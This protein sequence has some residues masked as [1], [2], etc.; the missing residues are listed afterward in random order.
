MSRDMAVNI[1]VLSICGAF[2]NA[3]RLLEQIRG[4]RE[5]YEGSTQGKNLLE[6]IQSQDLETSL[7]RGASVVQSQYDRDYK[8]YG[9]A[10]AR[11]DGELQCAKSLGCKS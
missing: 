4:F 7:H 3:A 1:C 8:R 5:S 9:I 11:G 2:Q 6:T 10:F